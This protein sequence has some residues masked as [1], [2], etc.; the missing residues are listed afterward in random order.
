MMPTAA[1]HQTAPAGLPPGSGLRAL[2]GDLAL[3]QARARQIRSSKMKQPRSPH[4]SRAYAAA[5]SSL[6]LIG[7][8]VLGGRLVASPRRR[9]SSTVRA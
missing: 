9:A 3:K 8:S 2:L 6:A 7:L 4:L 5:R 1:P